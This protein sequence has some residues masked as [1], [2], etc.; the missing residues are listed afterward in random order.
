MVPHPVKPDLSVC[1]ESNGVANAYSD[2]RA[3]RIVLLR[4]ERACAWT[5]E[6]LCDLELQLVFLQQRMHTDTATECLQLPI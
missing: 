6:L 5:G 1:R 3:G 4:I 2:K